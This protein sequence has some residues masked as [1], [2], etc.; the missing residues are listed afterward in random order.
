MLGLNAALLSPCAL[1]LEL[2]L[3]FKFSFSYRMP[4]SPTSQYLRMGQALNT[5]IVPQ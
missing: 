4:E 2:K 3:S 5:F 1:D